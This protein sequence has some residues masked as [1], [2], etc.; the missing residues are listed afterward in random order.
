M[1]FGSWN[2][3]PSFDKINSKLEILILHKAP[4]LVRLQHQ[5][6]VELTFVKIFYL[7]PNNPVL[8]IS[9]TNADMRIHI[10]RIKENW[11]NIILPK[12]DIIC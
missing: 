8:S 6:Y 11:V 5:N 12:V 3:W 9:E 2:F 10:R 1:T 7:F 4:E